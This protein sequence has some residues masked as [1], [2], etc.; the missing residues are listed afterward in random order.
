MIERILGAGL[1]FRLLIL[2]I[3]AAAMVLG[4][5]QLPNARVD[6][7]PEFAAPT[8]RIQTEALGLSAAEVEQ[9]VTVPLE[10][11]LLNG[12]AWVDEIR[13]ESMTGLS[14]IELVF[15]PGTTF[16]TPGRWCRSGW[17]THTSCPMFPSFP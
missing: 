11:N 17:R 2:P 10:Q 9:L 16:W 5:I 7:L 6:V 8:V 13:S 14:S 4:V 1:R 15:E 3:A 12:V